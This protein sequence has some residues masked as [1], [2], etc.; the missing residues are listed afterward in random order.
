MKPI[1]EKN[2]RKIF[3]IKGTIGKY[4]NLLEKTT[5]Q[6]KLLKKDTLWKKYIGKNV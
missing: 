5:R 1:V 3:Q 6:K 2:I 4:S